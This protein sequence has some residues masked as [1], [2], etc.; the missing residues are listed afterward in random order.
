MQSKVVNAVADA[1]IDGIGE[2]GWLRLDKRFG[3][4]TGIQ[5]RS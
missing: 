5:G 1:I 3:G 4:P 2:L